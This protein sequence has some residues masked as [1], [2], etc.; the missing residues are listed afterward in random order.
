[1]ISSVVRGFETTKKTVNHQNLHSSV[2]PLSTKIIKRPCL[3][4][5]F[6][7]LSGSISV[8]VLISFTS[9]ARNL[10]GKTGSEMVKKSKK[11]EEKCY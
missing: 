11:L 6:Y 7:L 9:F 10:G 3:L 1:M 8:T 4:S 2:A 5:M